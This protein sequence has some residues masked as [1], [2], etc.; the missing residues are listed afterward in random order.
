DML[1]AAGLR[2]QQTIALPDHADAGQLA[3][4]QR[5]VRGPVVCTEKDL[6]KQGDPPPG[7]QVWAVPLELA[8]DP[9]LF[10]EIDRRLGQRPA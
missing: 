5:P 1:V 6:V 10:A 9:G 8:I 3:A 4:A 2:P 7:V